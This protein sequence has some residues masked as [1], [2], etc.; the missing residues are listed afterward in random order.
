MLQHNHY[1]K[2]FSLV[3]QL[4]GGL[5]GG[6]VQSSVQAQSS[7]NDTLAVL[8]MAFAR[9]DESLVQ[10][11][12]TNVFFR[13]ATAAASFGMPPCKDCPHWFLSTLTSL[14]AYSDGNIH[15]WGKSNQSESCS[16][17][18][19]AC[20]NFGGVSWWESSSPCSTYFLVPKKLVVSAQFLVW[21]IWICS[22]RSLLFESWV[23]V[24]LSVAPDDWFESV[25]LKDILSCP[26]CCS[27]QKVCFIFL[28]QAYH[29]KSIS[30]GLSEC[31]SVTSLEERDALFALFLDDWLLC[32]PW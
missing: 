8:R 19:A 20:C 24:L 18:K 9:L 23:S 10:S 31:S 2:M 7:S 30:F 25:D 6:S 17:N 29:F 11:A 5:V 16:G 21:G 14:K 1:L 12:Q 26:S 28:N 13:Q 4:C 15:G 22:W 27:S 32:V 3:I